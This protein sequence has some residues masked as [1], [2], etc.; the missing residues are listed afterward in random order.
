MYA[1]AFFV[2]VGVTWPLWLGHS[3]FPQAP[4]FNWLTAVPHSI[5]GPFFVAALVSA[6][7]GRVLFRSP[8][9]FWLSET[10]SLIVMSALNQH[11]FQVWSYHLCL[12]GVIATCSTPRN[13]IARLRWLTIGIYGWSAF[14]KLDTGFASGIGRTLWTGLLTAVHLAPSSLPESL[15]R[16]APWCMPA[17]ELAA[18]VA[19]ALP[20]TRRIG[21]ALASVMHLSLLLAVG[22]FGLGHEW[23]VQLWNL[24]FLAQNFLLFGRG[25]AAPST[26]R[27]ASTVADRLG[28][29]LLLS[30]LAMPAFQPWGYWDIWPSWAVY[31]ARGG[32]TTTFVHHDD[33]E[34]LP[35]AVRPFVGE[36]PPLSD[37]HPI[38]VDA[39]SIR[40][41]HCPVYPQPRF[42]LAVAATLS[43]YARI[44]VERRTRPNR[45]SGGTLSTTLDV[46]DGQLP[47]EVEREFWLNAK[48]R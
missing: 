6:I 44:Q 47:I 31:S 34:K 15:N 9:F 43:R 28:L 5:D 17:G 1:A 35:N 33:I 27:E 7:V 37:W 8:R 22:P 41:L 19:L 4:A 38:D 45:W 39:W 2:L 11:R 14:S 46:S 42:R 30:A 21:L 18:A 23:A 12:A 13:A 36:P 25:S 32:W 29:C 40:E 3:T 10:A 26:E 24:L 48:S 16:I 20:R